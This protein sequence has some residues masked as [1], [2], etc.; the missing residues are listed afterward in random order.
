MASDPLAVVTKYA[1]LAL[2]P[3]VLLLTFLAAWT[4]RD[5]RWR[6]NLPRAVLR[7]GVAT[8]V[9]AGLLLVGY[10]LWG[11]GISVGVKFTTTG[12]KALEPTKTLMLLESLFYDIGLTIVLAIGGIALALRRRAWGNVL[13]MVVMLGAGSVIQASSVR[14]HEFVSLDKHT[15]FSG[16]FFAVPAAVALD[17]AF[18]RRGRSTVAALVIIWLLL[19][20]GMWRSSVQYSWP[21][22]V[23]EPVNVVQELNIPGQ[24][25]SFDSDTA[26]YYTTTDQGIEWY[27]SAE[28]YSVFGQGVA[29]VIQLEQSHQFVGF[30]FQTTNLSAQNLSELRVLDRY[31]AADPYYFK[32]GTFRVSPYS[33]PSGNCGFTIRLAI[34][35]Q[36]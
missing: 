25:F 10:R 29:Q 16:L 35:R 21:A 14:I 23:L 31:L 4:D 20:D 3:F 28:A 30:M 13:L 5:R 7:A 26:S 9:F 34:T 15:A 24:Y 1:G 27:S 32:T 12:R 19:I 6:R 2:V 33:R 11:S 8:V 36:P 17:W 18:S 22:S